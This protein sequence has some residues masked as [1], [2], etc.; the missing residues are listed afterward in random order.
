MLIHT[1]WAQPHYF[2]QTWTTVQC[3]DG[4]NTPQAVPGSCR[5]STYRLKH[6]TQHIVDFLKSNTPFDSSQN[7]QLKVWKRTFKF[8][9]FK[10]N[11]MSTLLCCKDPARRAGVTDLLF[12]F[13]FHALTSLPKVV[14]VQI[15]S[16]LLLCFPHEYS[17]SWL[18]T[19]TSK[20]S[21]G[22]PKHYTGAVTSEICP[23]FPPSPT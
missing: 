23:S 15:I 10:K 5:A 4:Q 2:K 14:I 9:L 8:R 13:S 18:K 20:A 19:P 1:F 17:T 12:L 16:I 7:T 3:L 11:S 21:K 22:P 6:A